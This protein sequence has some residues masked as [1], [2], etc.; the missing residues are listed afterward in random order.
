MVI[1]LLF[2]INVSFNFLLHINLVIFS[3][4]NKRIMKNWKCKIGVY[5]YETIGVQN[6]RG[7]VGGFSMSPLMREVE[8]CKRCGKVHFNP[9]DIATDAH[10][11][12]TLDWQPKLQTNIKY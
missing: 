2:G 4:F 12:E 1:G 5:N 11:D 10:L 3:N 7:V 6:A 8:K 9:F